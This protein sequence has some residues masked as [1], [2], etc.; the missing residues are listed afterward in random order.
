VY[1]RKEDRHNYDKE[2]RGQWA[3]LPDTRVLCLPFRG[4]G[5]HSYSELWLV[6]E[7]VDNRDKTF[8]ES[9]WANTLL[10]L[11]DWEKAFDKIHHDKLSEALT[12]IG[13]PK[14]FVSV[15]NSLYNQ[16]QFRV[17]MDTSTSEWETQHT[18]IRQGCP[19][20][21]YLFVIVMSVL[22]SDVHSHYH[23]NTAHQRIPGQVHDEVLYADDTIL[24]TTTVAAMNR[25]LAAVEAEG[26]YMGLRLNTKKM[27]LPR[28][29]TPRAR[30]NSRASG[31]TVR[32]S[33]VSRMSSQ[34]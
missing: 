29:W 16:P 21:P 5:V 20:S 10:V 15:I 6:V 18:G 19:L 3:S 17:R 30:Q 9:T 25:L 31:Q 13:L 27:R 34:Q 24:L 22:F 11:L 14:C 23:V 26:A 2:V 1:I 4:G 32:P 12:R 7:R 33:Q 28:L 8:G